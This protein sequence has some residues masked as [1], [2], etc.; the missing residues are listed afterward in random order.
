MRCSSRRES[1]PNQISHIS[2]RYQRARHIP[3]LVSSDV[4]SVHCRPD[5][6]DSV[7]RPF[8]GKL[9]FPNPSQRFPEAIT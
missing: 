5:G 4:Y 7:L 2:L 9:R 8:L 3:G 1:P 6:S